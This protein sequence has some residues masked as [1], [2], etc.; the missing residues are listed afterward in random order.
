MNVSPSQ[1]ALIAPT[2]SRSRFSGSTS[3]SFSSAISST[4]MTSLMVVSARV[5]P[6][7]KERMPPSGRQ[8]SSSSVPFSGTTIVYFLVDPSVKVTTGSGYSMNLPLP[9]I[10]RVRSSLKVI[11]SLGTS[12][13]K[14][15]SPDGSD[16][17]K[18]EVSRVARLQ[19]MVEISSLFSSVRPD[20]S[21]ACIRDRAPICLMLLPS[22][23]IVLSVWFFRS[24]VESS[25]APGPSIWTYA[26]DKWCRGD[27]RRASAILEQQFS[28]RP[29]Q[30]SFRRRSVLF[31]PSASQMGRAA[32]RRIWFQETSS[33]SIAQLRVVS[34][35]PSFSTPWR[36]ISF[37]EISRVTRCWSTREP[38][39]ASRIPAHP[40]SPRRLLARTRVSKSGH[41]LLLNSFARCG[42]PVSWMPHEPMNRCRMFSQCDT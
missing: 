37:W 26:M 29:F 10:A 31:K 2:R 39:I 19:F 41:A 14:E 23:R 5:L 20:C 7:A 40:S 8:K 33:D 21:E 28:S 4:E 6:K 42:A 34:I 18:V 16:L 25:I 3:V 38:S 32:S 27:V 17:L 36:A 11:L 12:M 30:S 22:T 1:K 13:S 15:Y 24:P 9:S 35:D